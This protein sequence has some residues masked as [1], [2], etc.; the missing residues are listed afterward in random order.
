MAGGAVVIFA[1]R[2]LTAKGSV[3][4]R[5]PPI[6]AVVFAARGLTAKGSVK[7]GKGG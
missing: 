7:R 4:G 5:C 3:K 6:M 1:A 2:G